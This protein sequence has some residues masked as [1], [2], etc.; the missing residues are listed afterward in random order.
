MTYRRN[1]P[2]IC[3]DCGVD[4]QVLSG[5]LV[6]GG[7]A[8]YCER[9]GWNFEMAGKC[10]RRI[11]WFAGLLVVACVA[12]YWLFIRFQ[13]NLEPV[14]FFAVF[15]WF[16]VGLLAFSALRGLRLRKGVT[17]ENPVQQT[18][19]QEVLANQKATVARVLR[20]NRPRKVHVPWT[21]LLFSIIPPFTFDRFLPKF[22][23]AI[24]VLWRSGDIRHTEVFDVIFLPLLVIV[25]VLSWS[26]TI[27]QWRLLRNFPVVEGVVRETKR[28]GRKS[29]FSYSFRSESSR[30]CVRGVTAFGSFLYDGMPVAVFYDPRNTDRSLILEAAELDLVIASDDRPLLAMLRQP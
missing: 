8:P 13:W 22:L 19:R 11:L 26:K 5:F 24:S 10:M 18:F 27:R 9:C 7:M 6:D 25:F 3:P 17:F 2:I 29:K 30:D 23:A 4:A 16:F 21:V 12:A 28:Q 15:A 14:L 20:L 1:K